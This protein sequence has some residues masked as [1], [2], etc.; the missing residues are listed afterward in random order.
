MALCKQHLILFFSWPQREE[1]QIVHKWVLPAK[2]T[3]A[4]KSYTHACLLATVTVDAGSSETFICLSPLPFH[5]SCSSWW[6]PQ[7]AAGVQQQ[8]RGQRAKANKPAH[9]HAQQ[10]SCQRLRQRP[11]H[12]W[13]A[14]NSLLYPAALHGARVQMMRS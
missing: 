12:R 5:T 3:L 8:G 13:C 1:G 10:T 14:D 9:I 11:A 6:Q 2:I 7:Q 4:Y